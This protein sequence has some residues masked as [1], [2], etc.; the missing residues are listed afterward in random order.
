MA[1]IHMGHSSRE[2]ARTEIKHD[3]SNSTNM[4]IDN[5]CDNTTPS[6]EVA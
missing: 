2:K 4:S 1:F 5:G 6:K 3:T